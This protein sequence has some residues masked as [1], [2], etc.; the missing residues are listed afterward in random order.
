VPT[1][2]MAGKQISLYFSIM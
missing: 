1:F 2:K